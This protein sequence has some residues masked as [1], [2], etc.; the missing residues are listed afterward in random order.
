MPPKKQAISPKTV[1]TSHVN[2][3]FDAIGAMLAA[4][5][6]YP[7][8]VIL[9]PGSQEKNLRDFFIH[10]M[11]YLFNMADPGTIDFSDTKRL[12]IVDTRQ[13]SR[14]S[15]VENLLEKPD[16][17]IDIYDHHPSLPGEI[18]GSFDLSK[19]YGA[20][21]TIMCELLR[22]K[23]IDISSDEATVMALGIYEDTGSFTYSSTTPADFEQAGF[24]IACGACLSTISSLVVKEMKTEQVT[25]LNELINEMTTVAVNGI[26]IHLSAIAA[27]HYIPDLASIVQKIVR[28]ENLDCFFALV[29]MG[30]KVHIIARNRLHELD[31]GKIL[32]AFGGGGHFYA[33]SAKVENQTLPQVEMRLMEIVEQQIRHVRVA[34]K[35]MSSPAI[36][37]TADK[38]CLDA[39]RKMSRYN[40]NTLLILDPQTL[41]YLGFIT[42]H[43]AEKIL[44]HKLGDQPVID[45]IESGT[46][47]VGLTSDLAEIEQKIIDLKQRVVPVI[48]NRAIVGVITRTDL[49]NFLVEHS[50]EVVL[51]EK[52]DITGLKPR[53]RYVGNLLNSR[54]KKSVRTLL[55]DIGHAG[56]TLGVEVFVVGGFVRDLMLERPNED[57]DVVVE[58]DGITFAEYFASQHN[59]RFHPHRK[60]NT[61][62]II[63]EDGYK[64]DVASARLE[65][66]ETP[67]ALPVVENS[68]IRM[69]LA[70]RDFT[71]NTLAISLNAE[72]FGTL[73]D[74]F[75]G[76]RDVKDRIVRI[77]HNLS[78]I[79]DPTR[80][81]RAIKFS[82]RFGFR[83]GKVTSNLISN[84]MNVGAVKNLSGLR[85]L[86]ELKQIFSE[87]NPLPAV[88][89]M[90]DYGL[91]KVIHHELKL[92]DATSALFESVGKILAWH[93]LL[94]ADDDYPRWAVYFM[95]WLHGYTVSVSTQ[96]AD[97]LMFPIKERELLLDQRIKAEQRIRLIERSYPVSNQQMYWW[98][99]Y[100]KTEILLF[101][102]ALTKNEPVRKAISHFYTHQRKIKPLAGGKDLKSAGI[103]PGP[104]YSTILDR[105]IDEKLDGKL[106]TLEEEIEFAKRYALENNLVL[107]C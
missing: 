89:T 29:L 102:L 11:G 28:M 104:V 3:D 74:Y 45:Y 84:A 25:W 31:V 30:S 99:I 44:H 39:A 36:S 35:L 87:E 46:Q 61:A 76:V 41:E 91:D 38:S 107:T 12:V 51:S 68:S 103:K 86:S 5:K 53:T 98:L 1:I 100:F 32:G 14:L 67:A 85:V 78:F 21:T 79:E 70:R 90:A 37:L 72:S 94:Y 20:T 65:Y 23:K 52:T 73:I 15:G 48:E 83:I 93:D 34:K 24:L 50:R 47:S 106:N 43:L 80:I 4:Q 71:I 92:T 95:A 105:I 69:D 81:F 97:R 59:C 26:R 77:I 55:S 62:V 22:E 49:L 6:L 66:Y 75:G 54:L 13:K 27:S 33:A 7:E 56:D 2:S 88:Q 58:G 17:I 18:K 42:R 57:I 10:S 19:P 96:I 16:L 63:F 101:M 9:F 64:L 40:I 8:G 60:F 82:N